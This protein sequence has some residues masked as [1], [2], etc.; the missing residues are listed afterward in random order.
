MAFP[1]VTQGA[2]NSVFFGV[3]EWTRTQLEQDQASSGGNICY[4]N[5]AAAGA[6]GGAA[7][8][9]LCSPMELAKIKL[10]MQIGKCAAY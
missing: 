5:V 9:F 4:K 8:A 7:Q 10:Q 1:L 2:L 6:L 3:Y